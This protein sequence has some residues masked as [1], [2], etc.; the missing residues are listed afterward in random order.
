MNRNS[1]SPIKSKKVNCWRHL[2]RKF[3]H[4]IGWNDWRLKVQIGIQLTC[5]ASVFFAAYYGFLVVFTKLVLTSRVLTLF[6][7]HL[8]PIYFDRVAADSFSSSFCY[9]KMENENRDLIR[10]LTSVY[11]DA[12]LYPTSYALNKVTL[13]D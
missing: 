13:S 7:Q 9:Q 4:R 10:Q 5:L 11:Q 8:T 1:R 12:L 6:S 3:R 2:K